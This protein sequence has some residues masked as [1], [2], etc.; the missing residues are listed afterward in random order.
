MKETEQSS[1]YVGPNVEH[2]PAYSKK[3]LFVVGKQGLDEITRLAREHKVTHIFMGANHSFDIDQ[4]NITHY[5]N[6]TIQS[7]LDR[8]FWVTLEYP[9]HQHELLLNTL[10]QFIWQSR[11]FVPLVGIR[12]PKL[13]TSNSNLTVKFGDSDFKETDPGVW[14]MHFHEVTDSNRFTDWV[15]YNNLWIIK[16][17]QKAQTQDTMSAFMGSLTAISEDDK[18][19]PM[20]PYIQPRPGLKADPI[21]LKTLKK[22]DEEIK[23]DET[24][25]LDPDAKSMLKGEAEKIIEKLDIS[26]LDAAEAYAGKE[27]TKKAKK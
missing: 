23:N 1:F 5:W 21:D 19:T 11:L 10:N 14:C 16:E 4:E 20:P 22:I 8:G 18:P 26:A 9:A 3:T 24:L 2:S 7:L 25:G 6:L 15:E 13:Q 27:P 17:E 12:I